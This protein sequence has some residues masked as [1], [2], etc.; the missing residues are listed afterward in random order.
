[1]NSMPSL[2]GD[3]SARRPTPMPM[4]DTGQKSVS[5]RRILIVDDSLVLLKVLG[6][7]LRSHGYE[8]LTATD[9]SAAISSAR[10]HKPDLMLLDIN[11]PPDVAHGGGVNWDA[12]TIMAWMR[13]SEDLAHIPVIII[14]S[15][16]P[17]VF[18][19]RSL[20]AGAVAFFRKPINHE[21]LLVA[22]RRVLGEPAI[23]A[24]PAL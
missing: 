8:V 14:T 7:K 1:M 15:G 4:L 17:S 24:S 10:Q 21:E 3:L 22:I 6:I 11:F 18:E 16:D 23:G 9:G 19:A 2:T 12:F 5:G 20:A 13:R